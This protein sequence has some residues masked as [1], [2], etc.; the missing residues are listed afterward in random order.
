MKIYDGTDGT[1]L[2]QYFA[3]ESTF[4]GGV[5]VAA[6]DTNGDGFADVITGTGVGGGPRV[7]VL[8]G[9]DDTELANYFAY[10]ESFR[11]GVLVG[12]GDVNGDGKAD[13]ITGTGV[14]GGP[15]VRALSGNTTTELANFFAYEDSFRG[16]VFAAAGNVTGSANAEIIAGTGFGGGPRVIAFDST[17][18]ATVA[19]FF[20]FDSKFRGGVSVSTV[21][22]DGDGVADIVVGSGAGL[23]SLI[24]VVSTANATLLEG[25][26]FAASFLGG[27]NVG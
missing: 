4:R 1:L 7:R 11:G 5:I 8:S 10:E 25:T 14:G 18:L 13:V 21:D 20:A 6:G 19:N 27:I 2:R 26:P 3:Y 16:G 23:P 15:R 24:R 9:I 22:R 12:A 17:T